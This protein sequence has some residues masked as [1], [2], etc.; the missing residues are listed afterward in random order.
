[1]KNSL[2]LIFTLTVLQSCDTD[3]D[4]QTILAPGS[5]AITSEQPL[6]AAY[7]FLQEAT[8]EEF[9]FGT[10]RSDIGRVESGE[11]PYSF[12]DIFDNNILNASDVIIQPYWF[13]LYRAINATNIA[14]EKA[15]EGSGA[16]VAEAKFLRAYSYFKLVQSFGGV[17]VNTIANVSPDEP[18]VFVRNTVSEVYTQIIADLN[19]AISGLGATKSD[20]VGRPSSF[21]AKALLA[22][23]HLTNGNAVSAEPLLL[24]VINNSDSALESSYADLFLDAGETSDEILFSVQYSA[25][26]DTFRNV[27]TNEVTGDFSKIIFPVH[28]DLINAYDP[29]DLRKEVTVDARRSAVKYLS[30]NGSTT[31]SEA[32]WIALRLADVILMYAEAAIINGS[33]TN[34]EVYALPGIVAIRT[35]AGLGPLKVLMRYKL[36]KTSVSSN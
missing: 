5:D 23:V 11:A 2:L 18:G 8:N 25:A 27:F 28:P 33:L 20:G 3:L 16:I 35:R 9:Y 30:D 24:D 14:V 19:D 34:A 29:A 10:I 31:S 4:Q 15:G 12:M 7:A 32:D 1:M 13:N 22:K 21:S 26:G 36:L 17:P 6:F